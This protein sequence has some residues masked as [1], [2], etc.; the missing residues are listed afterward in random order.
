MRS[1]QNPWLTAIQLCLAFMQSLWEFD[2]HKNIRF[3]LI[4]MENKQQSACLNQHINADYTPCQ[5]KQ[6]QYTAKGTTISF[7]IPN[8]TRIIYIFFW[9]TKIASRPS[10]WLISCVWGRIPSSM[11]K[12]YDLPK[13][14]K[15][16]GYFC[17]Y[18][19]TAYCIYIYKYIN[20][21]SAHLH[22]FAASCFAYIIQ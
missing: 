7:S 3:W 4:H 16:D 19:Y 8:L 2:C 10:S 21:D 15:K 13:T 1:V 22:T 12:G 5:Y 18:E 20:I 17:T 9:V 14:R 6:L 11:A